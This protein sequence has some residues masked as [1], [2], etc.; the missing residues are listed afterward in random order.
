MCSY[1]WRV[2]F[3]RFGEFKIVAAQE[4][5]DLGPHE[6]E[7][8]TYN[9]NVVWNLVQIVPWFVLILLLQ[10]EPN[11]T[12]QAWMILV[13]V[14]LVY[15]LS[16]LVERAL[17]AM[18]VDATPV[19]SVPM[20][21]G[22]LWLLSYKLQPLSA[23]K[24]FVVAAAILAAMGFLSAVCYSGLSPDTLTVT[25][26]LV[27][28]VGACAMLLAM[29]IARLFCRRS[30]STTRFMLWLLL[31][32]VLMCTCLMVPQ[33]I[34]MVGVMGSF[35]SGYAWVM[36][37]PAIV[38]GVMAGLV[39]YVIVVPFMILAFRNS[40]Y[41]ARFHSIFRL[42]VTAVEPASEAGEPDRELTG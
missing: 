38:G 33:A 41:R 42:G 34:I 26:V 13:P 21:L 18:G 28:A 31:C 27:Y 16:L 6:S 25:S 39:T 19:S 32:L 5:G 37:L 40:L 17:F 29:T 10:R 7:P 8:V 20:G 2:P 14:V 9:W 22:A 11:R 35:M 3:T 30:Y 23:R 15:G 36:V 12:R 1:S 4:I 24:A